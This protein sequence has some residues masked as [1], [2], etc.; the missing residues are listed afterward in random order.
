MSDEDIEVDSAVF[1]LR[2]K[3]RKS[4]GRMKNVAK[5]LKLRSHETGPSCNCTKFKCFENVSE[6]ERLQ[7]I[8]QFNELKDHDEQN[9]YL[10]GLISHGPVKRHRSRKNNDEDAEYH[11]Y[12]Y[13]YKIR[14]QRD[15]TAIEVPIC[16]KA[17]HGISAKRLQ[18]IQQPLT[19]FGHVKHHDITNKDK[20]LRLNGR[21]LSGWPTSLAASF[22]HCY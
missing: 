9:L 8:K 7:I 15:N 22:H 17:M 6:G 14:V 21:S 10:G 4:L 1:S 3:K 2:S 20:I 18:N 19:T 16:Y 11:S 13:T 12:S 5:L